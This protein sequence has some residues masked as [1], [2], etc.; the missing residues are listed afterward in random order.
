MTLDTD[1]YLKKKMIQRGIAQDKNLEET[2][3]D[4]KSNFLGDFI[5]KTES[6][7]E[8]EKQSER[9]KKM[10]KVKSSVGSGTVMMPAKASQAH[11]VM[12]EEERQRMEMQQEMARLEESVHLSNAAITAGVEEARK[13]ANKPANDLLAF[14]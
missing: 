13:A 3:D 14:E 4:Y 10:L 11:R 7:I 2:E 5:V 6:R 9:M 1:A 12:D 8:L